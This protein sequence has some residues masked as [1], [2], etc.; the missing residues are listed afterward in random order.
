MK[1]NKTL[2]IGVIVLVLGIGSW[3]GYTVFYKKE[4]VDV[5][6][7]IPSETSMVIEITDV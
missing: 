4:K 5:F 1:N 6:N 7:L 2:I 3:V